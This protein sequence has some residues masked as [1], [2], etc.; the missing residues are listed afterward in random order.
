MR[1]KSG[2]F[3]WVERAWLV[4]SPTRSMEITTSLQKRESLAG[5]APA[6]HTQGTGA[7]ERDVHELQTNLVWSRVGN[8][9]MSGAMRTYWA[10]EN[11]SDMISLHALDAEATYLY[12]TAASQTILGMDSK[13]VVGR[14]AFEFLKGPQDRSPLFREPQG[15]T[16]TLGSPS[17]P[18]TPILTPASD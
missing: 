6:A 12:C 9:M 17:H 18:I 3:I 15:R 1:H 4:L 14:S 13:Y 2:E 16:A 8:M 7:I 11:S 5:S 10:A